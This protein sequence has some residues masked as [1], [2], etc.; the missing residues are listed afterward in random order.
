MP[1]QLKNQLLRN[2]CFG[3]SII[4]KEYL[5][6]YKSSASAAARRITVL[7]GAYGPLQTVICSDSGTETRNDDFSKEDIS[8]HLNRVFIKNGTRGTL[9]Q[10]YFDQ[11]HTAFPSVAAFV[12]IEF[13]EKHCHQLYTPKQAFSGFDIFQTITV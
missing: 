1:F 3:I 9:Y 12:D 8:A 2:F 10:M 7:L 5:L 4:L 6:V 13:E 11:R